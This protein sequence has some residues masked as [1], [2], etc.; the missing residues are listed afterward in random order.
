M[1]NVGTQI[2]CQ[3]GQ[4]VHDA[5]AGG[6]HGVGRVFGELGAAHIGHDQPLVVALK[7]R[8]QR[9][10][11]QN[12]LL[13]AGAHH[14]AVWPH[15][16]F[17]RRTLFQELGVGHHR[18]RRVHAALRQLVSNGY[19]HLVCRAH[20]HRAFVDHRLVVGHQATNAA[21][22]REHVLHVGRAV[23]VGRRAHRNEQV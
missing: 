7:R 20:R 23:F 22:R 14:D 16:V 19:A 13:I 18:A 12:R 10:H 3:V 1:S 11:E 2:F 15:D 21:R 8:V 4:L 6:Q 17:H 5:D 9:A